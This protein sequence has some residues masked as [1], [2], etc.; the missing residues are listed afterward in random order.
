MSAFEIKWVP[1][2]RGKARVAPDPAYPKGKDVVIADS[3]QQS[4]HVDLPY[5][6]AECGMWLVV[7]RDCGLSVGVTAAGRPD[8]PRSLT[9]PCKAHGKL[10]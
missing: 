9:A 3:H 2:G 10:Q 4:C 7:C 6:A 1:S 5:P 8:D